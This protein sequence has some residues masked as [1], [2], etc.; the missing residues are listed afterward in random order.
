MVYVDGVDFYLRPELSAVR[1]RV[2]DERGTLKEL[3]V[4]H[5]SGAF[6]GVD[7]ENLAE[8]LGTSVDCIFTV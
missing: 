8:R 3:T 7:V 5:L 4:P 6:R 2:E 1:V